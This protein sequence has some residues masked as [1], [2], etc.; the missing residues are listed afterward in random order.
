MRI[1][2]LEFNITAFRFF[3]AGYEPPDFEL[4]AYTNRF[5]RES[6]RY[7]YCQL[8]LEHPKPRQRRIDFSIVSVFKS[9]DGNPIGKPLLDVRIEPDWTWSQWWIGWG[10]NEPGNW[11]PGV[12]NVDIFMMG[13]KVVGNFYE[14]Y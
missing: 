5:P 10:W 3:E 2:E 8:D 12:Y 1:Q 9:P 14:I 11:P 7:I 4:R 6:S 13:Q